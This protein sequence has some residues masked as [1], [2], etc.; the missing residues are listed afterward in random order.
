MEILELK[1]ELEDSDVQP[2][3]FFIITIVWNV[4][5]LIYC[6]EIQVIILF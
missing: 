5:F 2:F 4:L 1:F 3:S 6:L